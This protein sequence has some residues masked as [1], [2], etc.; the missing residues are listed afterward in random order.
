ML[1]ISKKYRK[2]AII[3]LFLFIFGITN[4]LNMIKKQMH[5]D[6]A[7]NIN[8]KLYNLFIFVN[9][10][11][12]ECKYKIKLG[13]KVQFRLDLSL[14][15]KMSIAYSLQIYQHNSNL[16]QQKTRLIKIKPALKI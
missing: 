11:L 16:Y 8:I 5:V 4:S 9:F 15:Q 12:H 10:I 2:Y 7:N 13:F 1:K 3:T 14:Y 6:N